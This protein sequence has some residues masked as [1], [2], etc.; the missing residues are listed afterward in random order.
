MVLPLYPYLSEEGGGYM[1]IVRLMGGLGNQ[2]FQ[3]AAARR[4]SIQQNTPLKLDLSFLEANTGHHTKRQFEL[5]KLNVDAEIAT[6]KD[7]Q[8]MRMLRWW[9]PFQSV[10]IKDKGFSHFSQKVAHATNQV[11]LD[12]FWQSEQYFKPIAD[13]IRNEFTFKQPLRDEY[14][15]RL[16][17]RIKDSDS[18]SLHFRRG[19]YVD[20]PDTNK[21]HGVCPIS[22]Y[23][24]AVNKIVPTLK[25]PHIFIFSDDIHWVKSHFKSE[26]P[27]VFI[28]Q[29]DEELH[30]DFRLMSMCKHNVIANSS[31]SW[32]AAWLNNNDQ[33]IVVAP[34]KWFQDP[35]SQLKSVEMIPNEWITM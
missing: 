30:S 25:N 10:R 26:L 1:V 31:Y 7:I 13:T 19:D 24:N 2:L 22:Y 20:N 35:K 12:G 11:F 6:E 23:Q 8:V 4:I 3:Y 16:I 5:H 9:K 18:V 32:W 28:E 27:L 21:F 14:F 34:K 15:L 33:K 29:S 17:D